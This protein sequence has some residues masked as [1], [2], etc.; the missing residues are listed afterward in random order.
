M[1]SSDF[2]VTRLMSHADGA[3]LTSEPATYYYSNELKVL[4]Y[5]NRSSV[6]SHPTTE[7]CPNSIR[8]LFTGDLRIDVLEFLGV[9]YRVCRPSWL[10]TDS[11]PFLHPQGHDTYPPHV[12][13]RHIDTMV[14]QQHCRITQCSRHCVAQLTRPDQGYW[15]ECRDSISKDRCRCMQRPNRFTE[16]AQTTQLGG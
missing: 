16:R 10:A 12:F 2:P 11:L 5:L 8:N 6:R 15:I 3:R 7:V 14:A 9:K 13:I 4:Y 1:S